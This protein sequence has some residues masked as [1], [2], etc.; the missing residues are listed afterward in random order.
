MHDFTSQ[1]QSVTCLSFQAGQI[2][3]VLNRDASGWWD[4]E[5]DGRRGW[6]PSNYVTSDVGLLSDEELPQ[7]IVS[8]PLYLHYVPVGCVRNGSTSSAVRRMR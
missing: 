1:Q 3:R 7:L 2:I 8:K 6:F 5:V 4:G